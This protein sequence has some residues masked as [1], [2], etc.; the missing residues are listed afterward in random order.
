MLTEMQKTQIRFYTGYS[1][2]YKFL[3]PRL[4]SVLDSMAPDAEILVAQILTSLVQVESTLLEASTTQ[5]AVKRVDEIEFFGARARTAEVRKVGRMYAARLSIITGVP[6]FSD[7]FGT[8]GYLGD[9]Y[10]GFGDRL[11][12]GGVFQL[13]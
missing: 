12:G 6:I 8:Q 4:E 5:A 3:H 7:I 11:L 9:R 13:G 2:I 1:N 10:S